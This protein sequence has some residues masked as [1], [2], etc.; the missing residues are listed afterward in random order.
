MAEKDAPPKDPH[1]WAVGLTPII[2]PTFRYLLFPS[3]IFAVSVAKGEVMGACFKEVGFGHEVAVT[4]TWMRE[5]TYAGQST[6]NE[7][8]SSFVM[9]TENQGPGHLESEGGDFA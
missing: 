9:S 8:T 6:K 2:P 1:T 7:L 4:R 3:V 5:N